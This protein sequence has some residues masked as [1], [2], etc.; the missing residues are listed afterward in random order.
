MLVAA[1]DG[2][3]EFVKLIEKGTIVGSGMQQPYL[4]GQR[5]A[6]AMLDHFAGKTTEEGDPGADP[7]GD[8]GKREA[9]GADHPQDG[10][11]RIAAVRSG[12]C[13]RSLDIWKR[14]GATT[15]LA[16]AGFTLQAGEVHALVGANGAG[17]STLSRIISGH[18]QPD[19]A[20]S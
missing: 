11:R 16:D 1:F 8:A 12:P 15:A 6:Q 18:I 2:I 3:P 14:F 5:S 7:G 20:R 9:G 10:L 13:S 19:R 4:M 17:K